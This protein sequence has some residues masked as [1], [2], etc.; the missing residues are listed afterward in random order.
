MTPY[1]QEEK[2]KMKTFFLMLLFAGLILGI[3]WF[4]SYYYQSEQILYIALGMSIL[5]NVWAYWFSDKAVLKMAKAREVSYQEAPELHRIV[6]NLAI[7]A[8]LPKP[9]V[10]IL[11]DPAPNAFATGRNTKH[12]VVAVSTGLLQQMN[13]TELE[14]VIAHELSHIRNYDMLIATVASVFVGMLSLVARMFFRG[15]S[16]RDNRGGS[17]LMIIGAV[18]IVILLPLIGTILRMAISRKREYLA[19]AGGAMLT[20]YPEGLASALE[21]IKNY[22]GEVR[23]TNEE[24]AHLFIANPFSDFGT[25]TKRFFSNIFSTHPPINERIRLLREMDLK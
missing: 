13:R 7:T 10:F 6:E 1:R 24:V 23:T 12:A 11:D 3:G 5:S 25:K 21:K 9:K 2:N 16:S 17:P 20:R 18:L 8:G 15:S 4:L 22:T 14:G 19:D